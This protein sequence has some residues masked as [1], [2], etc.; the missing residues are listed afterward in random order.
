ME[1]LARGALGVFQV[2]DMSGERDG[3][4]LGV[5]CVAGHALGDAEVFLVELAGE[6]KRGRGDL[7]E[8]FPKRGQLPGAD[9]AQTRGEARRGVSQAAMAQGVAL[10]ERQALQPGEERIGPPAFEET[11]G[12]ALE[13]FLR[14]LPVG[15]GA[16]F[17]EGFVVD[18]WRGTDEDESGEGGGVLQ[19]P[20]QGE[21]SA[22][23]VAEEDAGLAGADGGA[24]GLKEGQ[25]VREG[26]FP[27]RRWQRILAVAGQVGAVPLPVGGTATLQRVKIVAAAGESVKG[28]NRKSHGKGNW[29]RARQRGSQSLDNCFG[30]VRG[31]WAGKEKE[32][33][34]KGRLR[35]SWRRVFEL[36]MDAD[37]S[38]WSL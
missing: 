31:N 6:E 25:M 23:G 7:G 14:Q 12:A 13:D 11:G 26:N 9:A 3:G 4:G 21:A 36:Q 19:V 15:R 35:K 38:G 28:K 27:L 17:A 29:Q 8:T 32:I 34:S 10:A 5:G 37:K 33:R 24:G 16:F 22:H 2:G 1:D 30:D 18:P 20:V